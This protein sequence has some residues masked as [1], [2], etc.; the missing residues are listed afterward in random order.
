MDEPS[1]DAA[2]I[3][4][5]HGR[6][7]LTIACLQSIRR[8]EPV[9]PT[10][11]VVD[12][13]SLL[14]HV[15]RIRRL[16]FGNVGVIAAGRSGVSAA[17]NCGAAAAAGC[18]R[19]VFLNN[20]VLA[21]GPFLERLLEPLR[22][23]N[24]LMAGARLR[25]ETALPKETLARLPSNT[26]LEGWCLAVRRADFDAAGGFDESLR[27]YFSDTDLQGRLLAN[28]GRSADALAAVPGLPVRHLGHATTRALP[29]RRRKWREDRT[30]FLEIWCRRWGV[31]SC[32]S[33][34]SPTS[35]A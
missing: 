8:H 25:R 31:G 23:P 22:M 20:D 13:G 6:S 19:L 34:R 21:D 14:E 3:I 32:T 15:E 27:L 35:A 29:Q 16:Q 28:A 5:Q 11:I 24:C 30:R 4:P 33:C 10:A 7:D 2:L 9:P 18:S 26:F 12:D 17:W 1:I